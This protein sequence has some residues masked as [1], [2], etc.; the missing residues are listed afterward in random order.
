MR[1]FVL[2]WVTGGGC[3]GRDLPASL[4]REGALMRDR[5][6]L[7]LTRLAGVQVSLAQDPRLP[8]PDLPAAIHPVTGDPWASW[9]RLALEADACLPV[10]PEGEAGIIELYR[11]LAGTGRLLLGCRPDAVAIAADKAAT[12]AVLEG[13]G[14]RVPAG[15]LAA[16]PPGGWLVK[17]RRGAG[18]L[19][20]FRVPAERDPWQ[21]LDPA[22]EWRVEP[23][24]EGLPASLSLLCADGEAWLL[25]CNRQLIDDTGGRLRYRGSLVGGLEPRRRAFTPV[26]DAVAHALPGLW[27]LVGVDLVDAAEGPVVIEVNPRPTTSC[28]GLGRSLGLNPMALLL[29]LLHRPLRD[30]VRPLA[31]QPVEVPA[32][33]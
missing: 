16:A 7:D 12:C 1:V 11:A 27:G 23:W 33:G 15:E 18:C 28:A 29:E 4:A 14:L 19:D 30:L 17:P 24:I 2:E 9:L 6:A 25:A 3:L 32:D 20:T 10:A 8:A 31:P 26:A 5:L 21:G 22:A 13:A